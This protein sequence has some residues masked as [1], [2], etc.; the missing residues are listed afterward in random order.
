MRGAR[1]RGPLK[2]LTTRLPNLWADGYS[3]M[4]RSG[5]RDAGRTFPQ[6][7]PARL[8]PPETW[9]R[10]SS[11]E[12]RD[13]SALWVP[14]KG[15]LGGLGFRGLNPKPSPENPHRD[16]GLLRL[17]TPSRA[18]GATSWARWAPGIVS[19]SGGLGTPRCKVRHPGQN[20]QS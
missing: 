1:N 11:A 16:L 3:D 4:R 8:D 17:E 20:T 2:I 5:R 18:R 9:P 14:W 6:H 19:Q 7:A 12:D 15:S 10:D 13:A